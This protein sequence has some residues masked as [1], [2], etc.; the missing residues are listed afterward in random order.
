[1]NHYSHKYRFAKDEL[2][3]SRIKKNITVEKPVQIIFFTT[4][5]SMRQCC[6]RATLL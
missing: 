3:L 6:N 2:P 4:I 5:M 1:M